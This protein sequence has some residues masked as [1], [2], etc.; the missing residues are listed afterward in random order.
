[1]VLQ[2]QRYTM[3]VRLVCEQGKVD[4]RLVR[5]D[6]LILDLEIAGSLEKRQTIIAIIRIPDILQYYL[7]PFRIHRCFIFIDIVTRREIGQFNI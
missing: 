2:K 6:I 4:E 1:M 7:G 5:L 3:F